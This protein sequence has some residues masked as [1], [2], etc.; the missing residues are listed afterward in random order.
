MPIA[1]RSQLIGLFLAQTLALPSVAFAFPQFPEQLPNRAYTLS[2]ITG[3]QRPCISCHNNPDGGQGCV[4][5]TTNPASL[6][7]CL[8][9]FGQ[10]FKNNNKVWSQ[11]LSQLDSDGDGFSNGKELQ[12]PDGLWVYGQ[13]SPGTEAYATRP[14]FNTDS[15]GLYDLDNDNIC[16][17][18]NDTNDD[19]DCIDGGEPASGYDC[20]EADSQVSSAA[21]ELCSD[22]IDNDCNGLATYSDPL[23]ATVID[24]DGDGY[25]ET[26]RDNNGD[27]DCVDAGEA[28]GNVDCDDNNSTTYPGAPVNCV[29]GVDNDCDELI[30][31][32]DT[33]DCDVLDDD[34]DGYCPAGQDLN[35]DGRC[36]S[37]QAEAVNVSDCLDLPLAMNPNSALIS[38]GA[39]EACTDGL[40]NDCDGKADF[41]DANCA[42]LIDADDDGFCPQGTD[43]NNDG[44]CGGTGEATGKIDCD[45][46]NAA[47]SPNLTE[48]CYDNLDNDCDTQNNLDDGD[49]GRFI[50]VD[51]DG[52]CLNGEDT[53]SDGDCTDFH[54][55]K[56]EY[57]VVKADCDETSA[58]AKPR[59]G[60][61]S[62]V[63]DGCFDGIDTDCD[64]QVDYVDRD[65]WNWADRDKDG[66]CPYGIDSDGDGGCTDAGEATEQAQDCNDSN[67]A[68]SPGVQENCT[69]LQDNNCDEVLDKLDDDCKR[70]LQND[71]NDYPGDN[72][73]DG[74]G[75]C[76][77]GTDT[78][79]DGDCKD[80]GEN[81]GSDCNDADDKIFAGAPENT[82]GLC[83]DA[84][85]ND[86]DG[87]ADLANK[88]VSCSI[89][90]DDDHDGFCE[91]GQDKTFDGDCLDGG[92]STAG[93]DCNDENDQQSPIR[94]EVCTD[95]VDNNCNGRADYLDA[96]ACACTDNSQCDD[97]NSCTDDVCSKKR[98]KQTPSAMCMDGGTEPVADAGA[99]GGGNGSGTNGGSNN[100]GASTA[101][102]GSSNNNGGEPDA[103]DADISSPA[104]DCGVGRNTGSLPLW[105]F[106][107][108]IFGLCI[109]RR[110]RRSGGC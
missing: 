63:T 3:T 70:D 21:T 90:T 89:F 54:L 84:V 34:G 108:G 87:N 88:S 100:G 102:N 66:Y 92:E 10:A 80:K 93:Q 79:D 13:P 58:V 25:C 20:N 101:G 37:S 99:N 28:G 67:A 50:D 106:V 94:I 71:T 40:D 96:N 35:A 8:N 33:V 73:A 32:A 77:L 43:V 30:D 51:D 64:D 60:E 18:G 23:C 72:D 4:D 82:V 38:P 5:G 91:K 105:T 53:N 74:D 22:S 110:K 86:C 81:I 42:Y 47:R 69:D 78:N 7:P 17:F 76:P 12:D 41:V 14:G 68:K 19:G 39:S 49:C 98:C 52:F 26:G 11:A 31:L 56:Y 61:A 16:R 36:D 48:I 109:V 55:G 15:P 103:G 75:F 46:A 44:N 95:G 97:G 6:A 57:E 9:P 24:Q 85:D 1:K 59:S 27:N 45:D 83:K 62:G 107:L 65:C 2:N 29:D 104:P